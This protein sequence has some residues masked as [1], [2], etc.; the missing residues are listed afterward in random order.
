VT[1]SP[2]TPAQ[3]RV[4]PAL[5]PTAADVAAAM[6]LGPLTP[7][8]ESWLEDSTAAALAYVKA[9]SPYAW[10]LTDPDAP[11]ADL[12]QGALMLAAHLFQRRAAGVVAP[13][14]GGDSLT[15]TLDPALTRLLGLGSFAPPRVG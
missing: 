5:W 2:Q 10:Q 15:P 7:S 3:G 1:V 12:R 9:R 6:G 14:Y 13:D 11:T 8:D 4:T